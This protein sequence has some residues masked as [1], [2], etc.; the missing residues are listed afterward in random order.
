VG[1]LRRLVVVLV[2]LSLAGPGC[3]WVLRPFRRVPPPLV[4]VALDEAPPFIDDLDPDSLRTALEHSIRFYERKAGTTFLVAGRPYAGAD[5]AA[6]LRALVAALAAAPGPAALDLA[7][8]SG[9]R[10]LRSSGRDGQVLFTGY[11][12]P[13]VHGSRT[14]EGP[15]RHPLYAPPDDLV[16]V[17][18]ARLLPGC[19]CA[20]GA[21]AARRQDGTLL[22]YYTRAEIDRD[23]VL[24]GRGLE[25]VWADDP[26]ALFFLHMQGSGQVLLPDGE[27][28]NVNF[29]ATNGRPF[30]SIGRLLAERGALPRGGGSMPV[31]RS[32]LRDHP[33]ERDEILQRNERYTFFRIADTGPVGSTGVE[34]TPG[35]SIATDPAVFPPGALAYVRTRTPVMDD[36]GRATRWEPLRR[37]VLNQ[38][39]GVA[40]SG[41]GRVDVYFGSGEDAERVAGGM[42]AEGELYVL[43]PRVE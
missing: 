31:I 29:A 37:L 11:Y 8:R 35:R 32:Y 27:R 42:S 1:W 23:G 7:V 13:L 33:D 5:F 2:A 10:I 20:T 28:L 4:E 9:F 30:R 26:V 17:D 41:P 21:T 34:L 16:S 24:G 12:A 40:I 14:R 15:Y 43:V 3:A 22:P 36:D 19:P 18:L 6:A 25:I 38:D 39:A